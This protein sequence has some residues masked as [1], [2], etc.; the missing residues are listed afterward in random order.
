MKTKLRA[1]IYLVASIASGILYRCG[2]AGKPYNTKYRDLGVPTVAT[3]YLLTLGL[4]SSLW[5]VWGLLGAYLV[6]F[7]LLFGAL[8]TY[9]KKKGAPALWWNWLLTGLG[10]SLA[11]LPIAFVTGHWVG[12]GIRCFVLTG[13]TVLWSEIIDNVVVEE[14]GR[15]FLIVSTLPLLLI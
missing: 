4:K 1:F 15:G 13:L 3:L 11:A 9:W 2:G 12:F 8:T 14:F 7:G 10:Y 6:A 5:G